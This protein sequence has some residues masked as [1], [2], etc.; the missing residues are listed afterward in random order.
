MREFK[1]HISPLVIENMKLIIFGEILK[2]Q[3]KEVD[4]GKVIVMN[5]MNTVDGWEIE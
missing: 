4:V 3:F 5:D 2:E 1:T